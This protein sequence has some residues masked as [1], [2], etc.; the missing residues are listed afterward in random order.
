MKC[1]VL[2]LF[3]IFTSLIIKINSLYI[4]IGAKEKGCVKKYKKRNQEINIIFSI[5]GMEDYD[6][7]IITVDNP[8]NFN[9]YRELDSS[10]SKIYLFIEK[11]G[12]HKFCV[13]NLS[14][15]PITLSFHFGGEDSEDKLSTK[16]VESFIESVGKLS[17]KMETIKF[18]IGHAAINKK[19]HRIIMQ[20]LREKIN[21]YT[22][23]KIIFVLFFSIIQITLITSIFNKAKVVKRIKLN[24][25][26]NNPLK[27]K[28][29]NEIS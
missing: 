1:N 17:N 4:Y 19:N 24:E 18:N 9:M 8:D 16:N 2:F 13:D 23:L 11:D 7:N 21:L 12:Y 15:H 20:N 3:L 25:D 29:N 26:E 14:S 28:K 27:N 22:W 10:S 5:S 6:R